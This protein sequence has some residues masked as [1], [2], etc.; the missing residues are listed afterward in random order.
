[1]N[2]LKDQHG[3][4]GVSEI[5]FREVQRFSSPVLWVLILVPMVLVIGILAWGTVQQLWFGQPFGD[6][7]MSNSALIF[8]A[9]IAPLIT[10]SIL[11]L[12]ITAK[13]IVEVRA[14]GVY[15]RFIPFHRRFQRL[16]L[17]DVVKFQALQYRPIRE[18]GGWG[19][20][21]GWKGKAYNV[22][23]N[24]GV[25]FDFANGKH[26]LLGSQRAQELAEAVARIRQ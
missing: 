7:P 10:L 25:R 14:D 15:Y 3:N 2:G 18:Y 1:M 17:N 12:F 20:R 8:E 19:I 13:L 11:A 21:L 6:R 5:L 22:K 26:V 24:W 9:L 16:P 4:D 23:G